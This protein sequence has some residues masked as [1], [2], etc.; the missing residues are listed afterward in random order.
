MV[1]NITFHDNI[2]FQNF[3]WETIKEHPKLTV[4]E[5]SEMM[6]MNEQ[7]LKRYVFQKN[8]SLDKIR[9]LT[10]ILGLDV[11]VDIK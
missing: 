7:N 3:L 5:I 11:W 4:R 10:D 2:S 8:F 1:D 6:D 9:P